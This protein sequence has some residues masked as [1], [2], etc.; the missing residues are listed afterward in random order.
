MNAASISAMMAERYEVDAK[1]SR[2]S[3]QRAQGLAMERRQKADLTRE[4]PL[5]VLKRVFGY[6][7]FR[8]LQ[9]DII[10]ATLAGRDTVAILPTGAGK[11]L[12]YQL[13]ALMREGMTLVVSPLIALMKDQVDQMRA[14]GVAAG[15]LNSTLSAADLRTT[16]SE[17]DGGLFDLLYVAP[18]R[19]MTEEFLA[20]L[21]AWNLA[22]IVV[23]EAHCI[24]EWGHD[25]RPD[26]RSL[27]KLRERLPHVP[28]LALT[29]TAT[30][31]VRE[32][33]A[34][35]LR[36]R[37]PAQFLSSFNRSNL[38]Y[39]VVPK[40]D[41]L[42]QVRDFVA[43]RPGES[44]II[45]CRSRN[46]TET[47]A[48]SLQAEG[49]AAL[50]YHAGMDNASRSANQEAFIRDK[51]QVICATVAF[52]MGIN[53]PDVRYVIH[54]DLPMNVEGYYQQTGRA[55]RDGLPSECLMLFARGDAVMLRKMIDDSPDEEA[56]RIARAQLE[57]MIAYA[58]SADCRRAELLRHFGEEW[59]AGNCGNCDNCLQPRETWD[60]TV[61]AQKLLS[62]LYRIERKSGFSVGWKHV[63]D[64]LAG[65]DTEKIRRWGHD[66]LST[67]GIGR[68]RSRQEWVDLGR[69]LS[70]KGLAQVS[71][72]KYQTVSLS[73]EGLEALKQRTPVILSRTWPGEVMSERSESRPKREADGY[74]EG[75][76]DRL[77]SWRRT[78]ADER[79]VPA[80]VIFGD[81]TLRHIARAYPQSPE[82][83]RSVPGIGEKKLA[84]FGED[85]IRIVDEWLDDHSKREFAPT[86]PAAP[87]K[88]LRMGTTVVTTLSL[89]R[90]GH[91]VKMIAENRGLSPST[92]YRHLE[93]AIESGE[94][95]SMS[96]FFASE[97]IDALR[98]AFRKQD[99]FTLTPI[100]EQFGGTFDFDRLR[101]FRAFLNRESAE[102]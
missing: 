102:S 16:T 28:M 44:G 100:F 9:Q 12:C 11:S 49:I 22:A 73:D 32:D 50:P 53:K 81:V 18:E 35:Q 79:N 101:I 93:T 19:L 98:E 55:G 96:D 46:N 54:A 63:A 58:E 26:Y 21:D 5:S 80:Y 40:S 72:G 67:F 4:D 85:V 39:R 17:L 61:E 76:F 34:T 47:V 59:T 66:E 70:R 6:D 74:D 90:Q 86:K 82:R 10:Q 36:L 94:P 64:V 1:S 68:E 41:G 42:R 3:K 48:S 14:L 56:K 91:A 31:R 29:A 13:P 75:L 27:G 69:Q 88:E 99:S 62:C 20:R 51:A 95:L 84:E 83:L 37:E 57:R 65:A 92:I 45:Y 33:I 30:P 52:G 89:F 25:F 78:V 77:R 2:P 15:F 97:E 24:S 71:E 7:A 8:P 87:P 38:S 23:D 43:A 60:A